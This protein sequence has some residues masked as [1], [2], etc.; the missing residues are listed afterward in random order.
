MQPHKAPSN[1]AAALSQ[2]TNGGAV[3]SSSVQGSDGS[4]EWEDVS[5]VIL[6]SKDLPQVK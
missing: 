6:C 1:A 2:R 5:F 3:T 4:D